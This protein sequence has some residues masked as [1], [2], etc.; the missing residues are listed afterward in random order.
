M[1][2]AADKVKHNQ[3]RTKRRPQTRDGLASG[4]R[5]VKSFST[6]LLFIHNKHFDEMPHARRCDAA[7]LWRGALEITV[8]F[9]NILTG[10]EIVWKRIK[11]RETEWESSV[12]LQ[13]LS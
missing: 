3:T 11:G 5:P 1:C 13:K 8:G 2:A 12:R 7:N 6:H 9:S 4:Q 10:N